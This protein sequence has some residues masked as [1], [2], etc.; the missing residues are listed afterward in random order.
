MGRTRP[1]PHE[2]GRTRPPPHESGGV[3]VESFAVPKPDSSPVPEKPLKPSAVIVTGGKNH[4]GAPGDP[5]P[6]G[7]RAPRPPA[8]GD[9]PRRPPFSPRREGKVGGPPVARHERARQ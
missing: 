3:L 5:C 7:P 1:P 8:P 2:M 4:P 9:L 6:A